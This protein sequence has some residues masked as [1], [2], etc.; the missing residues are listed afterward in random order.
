VIREIYQKYK[1]HNHILT[2]VVNEVPELRSTSEL[3]SIDR[4]IHRASRIYLQVSEDQYAGMDIRVIHE[5]LNLRFSASIKNHL[6]EAKPPPSEEVFLN[7]L[8]TTILFYLTQLTLE[9]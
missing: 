6:A 7:N 2:G 8:T 9:T 3:C 1:R 5:F 4:L